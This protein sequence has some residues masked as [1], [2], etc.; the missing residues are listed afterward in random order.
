MKYLLLPLLLLT[1][2][3]GAQTRQNVFTKLIYVDS[4]SYVAA[5]VSYSGVVQFP[6][7]VLVSGFL[8]WGV[9]TILT[10]VDNAKIQR[11]IYVSTDGREYYPVA[12]YRDT[13]TYTTADIDYE[14]RYMEITEAPYKYIKPVI[15]L[16]DSV[17]SLTIRV[18]GHF[19]WRKP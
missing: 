7:D 2:G 8:L 13:I 10:T 11:E 18:D 5:D 17:Q 12:G 16:I 3:V 1:L 15:T 6:E 14:K 4:A 9:D 19:I